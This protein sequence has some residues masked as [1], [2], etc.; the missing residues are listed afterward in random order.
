M[1]AVTLM[2]ALRSALQES[3]RAVPV[4]TRNR[5]AGSAATTAVPA[6]HL[7]RLPSKDS[8]ASI[9]APVVLIQAME[10]YDEKGFSKVVIALRVVIWSEDPETGETDLHNVV[11]RIRTTLI[12][13]RGT[14]LD[15]RYVLEASDGGQWLPWHRPDDQA[16]QFHEGYI[17]SHWHMHGF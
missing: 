10:G 8:G 6:V 12:E 14:P 2:Q 7:G 15:Q 3:L 17:L 11:S 16:P 9:D 5:A 4:L 1:T 13:F